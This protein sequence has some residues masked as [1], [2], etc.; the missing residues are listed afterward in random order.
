[1]NIELNCV[2]GQRTFLDVKFLPF[3][4]ATR[5]FIFGVVGPTSRKSVFQNQIKIGVSGLYAY[6]FLF[7]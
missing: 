1:M 5:E 2:S 3:Y 6:S 7:I 4:R